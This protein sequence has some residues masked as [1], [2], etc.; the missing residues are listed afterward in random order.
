MDILEQ[1]LVYVFGGGLI[2]ALSVVVTLNQVKR[3]AKL[4]NDTS[5]VSIMSN[6]INEYQDYITSLKED[7]AAAIQERDKALEERDVYKQ[8]TAQL[9]EEINELKRKLAVVEGQLS[10][11]QVKLSGLEIESGD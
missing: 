4:D 10:M 9:W 11:A 1:V 6:I 3:K 8:Q 2:S 7:R 5:E